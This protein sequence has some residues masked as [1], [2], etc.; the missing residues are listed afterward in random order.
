MKKGC[1]AAIAVIGAFILFSIFT[2]GYLSAERV[3][4]ED[5]NCGGQAFC[6][7]GLD[8]WIGCTDENPCTGGAT[9]KCTKPNPI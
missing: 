4:C 5:K 1:K 6:Q 7:N 9:M 2:I 8:K 3:T